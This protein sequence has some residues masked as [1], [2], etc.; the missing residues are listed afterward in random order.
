MFA[1]KYVM[2]ALMK[3]ANPSAKHFASRVSMISQSS[4]LKKHTLGHLFRSTNL[5]FAYATRRAFATAASA[6]PEEMLQG[7]SSQKRIT[8]KTLCE[9]T[10]TK[11]YLHNNEIG[12]NPDRKV[13]VYDENDVL[14]GELTF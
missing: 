1:K 6:S 12:F 10:G 8:A 14:V 3:Q 4:G 9:I 13:K 11:Y 7:S 2:N 5:S